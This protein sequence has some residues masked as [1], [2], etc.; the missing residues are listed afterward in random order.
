MWKWTAQKWHNIF[1]CFCLIPC[2]CSIFYCEEKL[3]ETIPT[4]NKPN[5]LRAEA[6]CKEICNKM[7]W[8]ACEMAALVAAVTCTYKDFNLIAAVVMNHWVTDASQP[9]RCLQKNHPLLAFQS[10]VNFF[11]S[12]ALVLENDH[13]HPEGNDR[14]NQDGVYSTILSPLVHLQSTERAQWDPLRI[15]SQHFYHKYLSDWLN[16]SFT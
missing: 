4:I 7:V 5:K 2:A 8:P 13:K 14:A 6:F 16:F 11:T 15:I 3:N 10:P 1:C 9:K 12:A